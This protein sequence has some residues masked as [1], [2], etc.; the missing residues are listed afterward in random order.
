MIRFGQFRLVP[1]QR[2]LL[3]GDEPVPVGGKALDLL[4]ALATRAGKLV[5]KETLAAE[6]WK[7][8]VVGEG[9]LRV[10]M[11]ALRKALGDEGD[12]RLICTVPGQ[13]YQFV[14]PVSYAEEGH[15]GALPTIGIARQSRSLLPRILGRDDFIQAVLAQLPSKRLISIVGPG[16]VGK[17]RVAVA[18]AEALAPSYRDGWRFVDLAPIEDAALLPAALAAAL[19]V[20]PPADDPIGGLISCLAEQEMLLV[21]D[22]CEHLIGA[23]ASLGKAISE[24]AAGVHI[25]ATSREPLRVGG[26]FVRRL[27][28]LPCPPPSEAL[29]AA[30]ALRYPAVQLFVD[31]VTFGQGDFELSDEDAP[32]VGEICRRL[33]GLALAIELAAGWADVLGIRSLAAH[34]DEPLR[35]LTRGRRTAPVRHQ[36]W[37]KLLDWSY[38]LLPEPERAV[39][40]RVAVFGGA[41]T[42]GAATAVAADEAI[43]AAEVIHALGELVSKSLIASDLVGSRP[44][45]RLLETTRRYARG[46]LRER[47]DEELA[48]GRLAKHMNISLCAAPC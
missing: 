42:P 7:G 8:V 13:G 36:T 23:A 46:K 9:S 17:T 33:D 43:E 11:A 47:G 25:L 35:I 28:P 6:V 18:C 15:T 44:H 37:A 1:R 26:E 30:E 3:K 29:T 38:A 40:C 10:Q 21:L 4:V 32:F 2:L 31:C 14:A 19:G 41:F 12:D 39:L 24:R 20:V 16:G 22:N 27:S 45:F 48:L 34:L 5:T